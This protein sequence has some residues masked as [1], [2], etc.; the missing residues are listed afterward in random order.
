MSVCMSGT[1][2]C[3]GSSQWGLGVTEMT[4]RCRLEVWESGL[5]WA[6]LP[7]LCGAESRR[8]N[9]IVPRGQG[10]PRLHCHIGTQL[11][12]WKRLILFHKVPL[13]PS[14]PVSKLIPHPPPHTHL[15]GEFLSQ[16]PQWTPPQPTP[17]VQSAFLYMWEAMTVQRGS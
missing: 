2:E 6:G 11:E 3:S 10:P 1:W 4:S 9:G 8:S 7:A 15:W 17:V 13:T 14:G 5:H 16:T 12:W